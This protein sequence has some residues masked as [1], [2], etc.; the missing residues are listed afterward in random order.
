M[1]VEEIIL[2]LP[3]T[4]PEQDSDDLSASHH[5]QS[6]HEELVRRYHHLLK[7]KRRF[8]WTRRA[9]RRR[10]EAFDTACKSLAKQL[11]RVSTAELENRTARLDTRT[12]IY[13]AV[14]SLLS[15]SA[16]EADRAALRNHYAV[17]YALFFGVLSGVLLAA[18]IAFSFGSGNPL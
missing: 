15:V 17:R 11:A 1:A 6:G 5:S 8:A 9:R 18:L 7:G 2:S 3:Q 13:V 12:R 10:E 16:M 14:E 4:A